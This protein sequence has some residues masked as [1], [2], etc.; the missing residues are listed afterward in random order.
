MESDSQIV[1]LVTTDVPDGIYLEVLFPLEEP[2]LPDGAPV[3]V[4]VH[5]GLYTDVVP[6]ERFLVDR[7][8]GLV[9]VYLNLPGGNGEYSTPGTDDQRGESSRLALAQALRYAA[10]ELA[11]EDGVFLSELVPVD[12][13]DLP[14]L[15]H[16]QSNGVNLAL[17]TMADA[18]LALPEISGLSAFESPISAQFVSME[19]GTEQE[20]LPVY[21]DGCCSWDQESG[22]VCD[23][24]YS[25]LAWDSDAW[26]EQ[27]DRQGVV[28]LDLDHDGYYGEGDFPF[29][30][31]QVDSSQQI[32][33]SP[34]LSTEIENRAMDAGP[35][36]STADSRDFWSTRDGSLLPGDVFARFPDLPLL[37]MG[38]EVDHV[39]GVTDHAH[40]TGF[41]WAAQESGAPWVRVNPGADYLAACLPGDLD[42]AENAPN[43]VS[44]PGDPAISMLPEETDLGV[45]SATLVAVAITELV[46]LSY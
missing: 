6:V 2:M 33:Y 9:Q 15:V 4:V 26:W 3:V 37:V 35:A 10:G 29:Y 17:A 19:L 27:G 32:A 25:D 34:R 43:S 11:D 1:R 30:G 18:E 38:T 23:V 21:Q 13:L 42:Y 20:P 39:S 45:S 36:M 16:G 14:P 31:V 22:L 7:F 28:F 40:V 46:E 24:D 5:G 44:R 41:A 12:L 8:A